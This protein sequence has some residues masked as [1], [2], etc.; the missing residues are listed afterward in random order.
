MRD[1]TLNIPT[2]FEDSSSEDFVLGVKA[3][4]SF[5]A[6][7]F[8]GFAASSGAAGLSILLFEDAVMDGVDVSG[9][10]GIAGDE[11]VRNPVCDG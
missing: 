4:R 6:G 9:S 10:A 7:E 8:T 3:S 5:A 1:S 2:P 11:V